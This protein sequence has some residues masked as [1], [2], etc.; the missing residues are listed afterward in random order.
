MATA[1]H[2]FCDSYSKLPDRSLEC[3]VHDG[4]QAPESYSMIFNK[5]ITHPRKSKQS[6]SRIL[7]VSR[8]QKSG[9]VQ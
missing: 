9:H 7:W 3:A 2:D 4:R 1:Q 6:E 5:H 8:E